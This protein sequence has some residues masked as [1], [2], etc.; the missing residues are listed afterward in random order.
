[1]DE[2]IQRSLGGKLALWA[3]Y[4]FYFYFL[5]MMVR[6]F[7]VVSGIQAPPGAASDGPMTTI[8]GHWLSALLGAGV[9]GAVGML[10]GAIAWYTRPRED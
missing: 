9:L 6:F 4:A 7:W 1:M 10:L 3:F 5:W 2:K 8:S